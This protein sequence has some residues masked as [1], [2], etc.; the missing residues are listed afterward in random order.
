[1]T[2][3]FSIHVKQH[4]GP[5][6]ENYINENLIKTALRDYI[7]ESIAWVDVYDDTPEP[8]NKKSELGE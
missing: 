5:L 2:K 8:E 1:M 7:P 4:S 6:P 3:I